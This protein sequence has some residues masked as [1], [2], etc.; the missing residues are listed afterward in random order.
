METIEHMKIEFRMADSM[1]ISKERIIKPRVPQT[2][3]VP[4]LIPV[5]IIMDLT[6]GNGVDGRLPR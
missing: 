5:E 1:D 2:S 3:V 4:I 6:C